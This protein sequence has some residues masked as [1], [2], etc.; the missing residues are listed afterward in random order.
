MNQLFFGDKLNVFRKHIKDESVDLIR[1]VTIKEQPVYSIREAT[2]NWKGLSC[3]S[4]ESIREVKTLLRE[5][6][7]IK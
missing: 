3:A 4:V 2:D 5:V 1:V 6:N 7:G